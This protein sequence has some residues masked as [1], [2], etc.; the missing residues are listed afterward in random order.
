MPTNEELLAQLK[1]LSSELDKRA[2]RHDRVEPYFEPH[3]DCL[4]IPAAITEAKLTNTY[5]TLMA[6]SETPWGKTVVNAK[7]DRLEVTGLESPDKAISIAV[8]EQVWQS[9][10]MDLE[11]KLGHQAALIDGRFHTLTWPGRN[12]PRVTLDDVTQMVVEYAE[13]SRRDR[14][15]ALRR[16]RD[17]DDTTY[18]T[19]YRQDG[20]YKF[21]KAS[22]D[23]TGAE[24]K[25]RDVPG[26]TWPL[27]NPLGI[28]PVVE[29]GV[30]RRLKPG[31][32]AHCRGEY[33]DVTGLM[34]RINLLT[35]LG[36]VVALWMGF[37]LRGTIGERIIRDD[38]GN[39][40]PPFDVNADGFFQLENP[41][42]K[43]AEYAAADRKNLSVFA[44]LTELAAATSTPRHYLPMDGGISNVSEPTIR[45]FEGGMH[46]TVNASHKPSLGEGWEETCRVGG[47]M[48]PEPVDLSPTAN[49]LWADHE[50][51]SLG[52][53][54]DAAL[55]LQ[56]AG[57]PWQAVATIA[58]NLNQDQISQYEAAQSSSAL[59][60]IIRAATQPTDTT[61]PPVPVPA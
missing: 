46:A 6:M 55:K 56:Q 48:L 58:L 53:R 52:E 42:A 45:A 11:S 34:D 31:R 9:N 15:G 27:A 20:I 37:P 7:L 36:L 8:W 23:E 28:V 39:T 26:E 18:A 57:L 22:P 54:A 50:S 16:W 51:R 14:V 60:S 21:R 44:E 41:D 4:A 12:G 49:I 29:V 61:Q 33:E 30:N 1:R 32:F 19:L 5:K 10:S 47:L 17:D 43:L 2:R 13:G 35:F 25:R 3:E 40:L 38:D 59:A 24:W